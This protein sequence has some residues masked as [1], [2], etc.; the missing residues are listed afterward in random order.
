MN[1]SNKAVAKHQYCHRQSS[2][3]TNKI[4]STILLKKNPLL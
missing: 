3:L 4:V 1:Q 2:F